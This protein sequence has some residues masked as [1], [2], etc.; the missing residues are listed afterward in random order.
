MQGHPAPTATVNADTDLYDKPA[1]Q[2]GHK[3]GVLNTGHVVKVDTTKNSA[4][5]SNAWCYPDRPHERG[6]GKRRDE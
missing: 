3:I 5:S 4:C 6:L 1:D 2:G